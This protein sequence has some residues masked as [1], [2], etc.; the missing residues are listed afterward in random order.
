M[1]FMSV[2]MVATEEEMISAKLKHDVRDYCAHKL[3]DF[4]VCRRDNWPW[5]VKCSHEK[6]AYLTCQY[7][8]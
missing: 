8:E 1:R 6:H 4:A 3:I 5:V 2:V 7:E